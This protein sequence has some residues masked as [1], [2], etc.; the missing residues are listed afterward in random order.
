[1][2]TNSGE[3]SPSLSEAVLYEVSKKTGESPKELNPPLFD[4]IDPEALDSIFRADTGH[5]SFEYH[6]YVVTVSH[7]GTVNLEPAEAD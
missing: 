5:V 2:R 6:G 1:M 7:A 3:D 4:V